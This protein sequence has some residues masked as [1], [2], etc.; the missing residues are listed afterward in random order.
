MQLVVVP[1]SGSSPYGCPARDARTLTGHDRPRG[2]PV[3]PAPFLV[4][5]LHDL[6]DA[7]DL[8]TAPAVPAVF[9][10]LAERFLR[11]AA[12]GYA[13]CLASGLLRADWTRL[14]LDDEFR[15]GP[16]QRLRD[17]DLGALASRVPGPDLLTRLVV[18]T[19][20]R[21]RAYA[22][23]DGQVEVRRLR[24][25]APAHDTDSERWALT[26]AYALVLTREAR[27]VRVVEVH[28]ADATGRE[29]LDADADAIA[30]RWAVEVLPALG[31][32]AGRVGEHAPGGC[33][34][35]CAWLRS[36]T[37]RERPP[38]LRPVRLPTVQAAEDPELFEVLA[39]SPADLRAA[40]QCPA[41]A[42]AGLMRL[43]RD[44][45]EDDGERAGGRERGSA[46]H[47]WYA[48]AH[49]RRVPCSPGD[50]ADADLAE[51]AGA[52]YD[53]ALPYLAGHPDVC[54][55]QR[56][57]TDRP[58]HRA[59]EERFAAYD[60][61]A[62]VVLAVRPDLVTRYRDG[63]VLRELKTA[64]APPYRTAEQVV[65]ADMAAAAYLTVLAAGALGA[66]RRVEWEVLTPGEAVVVELDAGDRD[67]VARAGRRVARAA[68]AV[69]QPLREGR[70]AAVTPSATACPA[71]PYNRW[72]TAGRALLEPAAGQR[73]SNVASP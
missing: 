25:A 6:C 68:A 55:L 49:A 3:S 14:D 27:R 36:C 46:V 8:G 35:D 48:A 29:V 18:G 15:R 16:A 24:L 38:A 23:P 58:L 45:G 17:P 47:A 41:R 73:T 52:A 44:T 65:D 42:A 56:D 5:P 26:A 22:G 11:A 51:A 64:T 2:R 71:C 39:L 4:G 33:C 30:A 60:A 66:G 53:E 57:T 32:L 12:D 13:R 70:P 37:E 10:P 20:W 28:C 72:C 19:G 54:P 67:L 62:G 34:A 50:L 9:G 21:L 69:L 7:V 31:T 63:T 1:S 43:P 40:E 61:D 59:A